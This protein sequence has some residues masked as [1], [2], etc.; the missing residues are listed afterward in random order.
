MLT[1]DAHCPPHVLANFLIRHQNIGQ[2]WIHPGQTSVP[3]ELQNRSLQKLRSHT[4]QQTSN[5][6]LHELTVLGGPS[7]YLIPLL[8]AIHPATCIRNLSLRFEEDSTSN[9]FCAVLDVTQH[10]T[11]IHALQLSFFDASNNASHYDVPCDEH[12]TVPAKQLTVSVYGPDPD[13][14]LVSSP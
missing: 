2:V 14:L 3:L 12:R 13:D 8:A 4:S 10:F 7:W 9:H 1:V 5:S 11:S 6:H